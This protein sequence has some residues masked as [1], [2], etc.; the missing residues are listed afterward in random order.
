MDSLVNAKGECEQ[1]DSCID[2]SESPYRLYRFLT[3]IENLLEENLSDRS[4]I[5]AICP[6]VR[7]LLTSSSWIQLAGLEP[8]PDLGWAVNTLYDE[9]D[10]PL[11]VQL[12][13]WLPHQVSPIHNHGA[14]GVVAIISGLETNYLWQ[15]A[16][17]LKYPH[18]IRPMGEHILKAGEI[19]GFEP[20]AIHSIEA[21]EPTFSFNL[22]GETKYDR[23]FEFN[24]AK[25]TAQLF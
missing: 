12:V 24:I 10:F 15:R 19:I 17:D 6:L 18:K 25:S 14:W 3:D 20:A 21:L 23:R 2:F 13:S 8:D 9:P 1:L 7:R 5:Q 4:L 11:T 22:Y 16:G